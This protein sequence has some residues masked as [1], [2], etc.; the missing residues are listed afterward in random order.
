MVE[1][2][3]IS[4]DFSPTSSSRHMHIH[5]PVSIGTINWDWMVASG[6]STGVIC[7]FKGNTD[8]VI[9]NGKASVRATLRSAGAITR[10]LFSSNNHGLR[11]GPPDTEKWD[12]EFVAI[13][14]EYGSIV[15][16]DANNGKPA[17][18]QER[19]HRSRVTS[20]AFIDTTKLVS[21]S[22]KED[23]VNVWDIQPASVSPTS[24]QCIKVVG[25]PTP[26]GGRPPVGELDIRTSSAF[27]FTSCVKVI[28]GFI[29]V[30]STGTA[31]RY[32]MVLQ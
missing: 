19:G 8:G 28:H 2:A 26:E 21:G 30:A 4:H 1:K 12:K 24:G 29:A 5:S 15:V 25:K 16:L 13:G 11:E 9:G 32:I 14:T 6:D 18:R 27:G 31:S 7:I 17:F 3:D 20:L 10:I 23:N 22:D